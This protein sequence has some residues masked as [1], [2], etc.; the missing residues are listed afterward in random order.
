[1]SVPVADAY[2]GVLIN[3]EGEVLL[4]EPA[5]HFGGYV[6]TFAKGRPEPGE[7]P[8]ETALREVL[9]ETGQEARIVAP[10]PEVFAGTTSSTVFFLM[11][12]VGAPGPFSR[13][14]IRVRWVDPKTARRLISRTKSLTGRERDLLVLEAARAVHKGSR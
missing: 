5:G 4:R 7:T 10:I 11:E 14:T 8:E 12:P 3:N 6:W 1:M 9:E 13:E 2:G